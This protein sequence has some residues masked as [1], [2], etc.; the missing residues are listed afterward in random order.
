M[1]PC[2]PETPAEVYGMELA[3]G[4]VLEMVVRDQELHLVP[5]RITH[6]V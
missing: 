4:K 2:P 3:P 5:V 1:V 6:M